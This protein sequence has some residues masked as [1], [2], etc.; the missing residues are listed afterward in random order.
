MSGIID[1]HM[2]CFTGQAYAPDVLRNIK[3]LRQAGVRH[4]TVAGLINTK[5]DSDSMWG[6]IPDFVENRGD[7]L[8][9]EVGNLLK[10]T[11]LSDQMIVP[12]VDTRHLWG[13]VP[14]VLNGH[15]RQGFKGIKGIYLPDKNNDLG[16]RGVPDTFDI[17]LKQYRQR[18]WE[19]FSFA[20]S[21]DLPLLYHMDAR[22][23]GDE[24]IALLDDFPRVRIDFAHLG[25]SRKTFSKILDRYPA[26]YADI[27][28]LLPHIRNNPKSYRD[29][30]LHYPD[31][32]CFGS[33][34]FLYQ[35][36]TVLDYVKVVKD[37]K[38]PEEIELQVFNRNPARFL[39]CA[40]QR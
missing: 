3:K 21:H 22:R 40:L 24:M 35:A 9:N 17:S 4:L 8:F 29:F 37:L 23:Y 31:R 18:E 33:D 32:I 12:L 16:V 38:L 28:G 30:I 39:G 6:L 11:G 27:A 25:L 7:P 34:A 13:T 14:I 20:Q 36:E 2:H 26:V 19:I 10:F 15:L 5:L 1:V